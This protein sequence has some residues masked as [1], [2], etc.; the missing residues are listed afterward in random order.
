MKR[1]FLLGIIV[2]GLLGTAC[3]KNNEH[4]SVLGNWYCDEVPGQ[5]M[6]RTYQVNIT[7]S[8]VI[9]T[10]FYISNFYQM[11][12]TEEVQVF[13]YQNP[14]GG[15]VIYNQLIGNKA[16]YGTGTVIDNYKSIEW[17]YQVSDGSLNE[18]VKATYY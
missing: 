10:L 11:G 13:F 5:S 17:D 6:P 3:Q 4:I 14:D 8:P 2:L 9:D 16:I 1:F 15:L 12:F 18:R 7:R